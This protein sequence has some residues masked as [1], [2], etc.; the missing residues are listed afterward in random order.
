VDWGDVATWVTGCL[1]A[2]A[3]LFAGLQLR[4]VQRQRDR[5]RQVDVD[6]VAVTWDATPVFHPDAG[7]DDDSDATWRIAVHNP[8]DLPIRDVVVKLDFPCDAQVAHSSGQAAPTAGGLELDTPT[9]EGRGQRVWTRTVRVRFAD[10]E[11]LRMTTATV[12]FVDVQNQMRTN[13][14]GRGARPAAASSD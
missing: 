10:R 12:T 1:T 2:M 9:V 14:W 3:L 13:H 5:V 7:P 4:E 6:G 11:Q 8:G